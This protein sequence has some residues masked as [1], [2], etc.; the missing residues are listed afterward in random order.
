[1]TEQ[2][3]PQLPPQVSAEVS[4]QVSPQ[5]SAED[6]QVVRQQDPQVLPASRDHARLR[7]RYRS[8]APRYEAYSAPAALLRAS[9]VALL[10]PRPGEVVLDVGCG[11]GSNFSAICTG[12]G[13]TGHLVAV[14]T[15]SEM[16]A[17]ARAK[18][19]R[20]G[21]QNVTLVESTIEDAPLPD[22]A[23]AALLSM[24]HG[25]MRSPP[26]LERVVRSLRPGGRVVA[27]GPKFVTA[28]AGSSWSR[29]W[30]APWWKPVLDQLVREVNEPCVTSFEGFERPWEHLVPLLPDL[31]VLVDPWDVTY[32]AWGTVPR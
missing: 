14:D 13:A 16:L 12:I 27:A 21:W 6:L 23:D 30:W 18:V 24:V 32:L 1:M 4:A 31:R 15:C 20:R 26:A 2:V 9:A 17:Q 22:G 11:T 5:V 10:A 19:E 29:G 28:G 8:L 3:A 7:A 25:V